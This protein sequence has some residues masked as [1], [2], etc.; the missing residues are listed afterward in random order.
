[1]ETPL[2]WG[3]RG[4]QRAVAVEAQRASRTGRAFTLVRINLGGPPPLEQRD[5]LRRVVLSEL[6][7]TDFVHET[8]AGEL[9]VLL[10]ETAGPEATTPI[11]RVREALGQAMP[12]IHVSIGSAGAGPGTGRS[13]QEAWR[14]AGTLLVADAAVPAAA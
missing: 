4:L 3:L 11:E 5:I 2:F 12:E 7:G 6:R 1:M 9:G 13:W 10:P 8:R 14:W